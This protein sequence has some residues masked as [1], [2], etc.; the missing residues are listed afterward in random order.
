MAE[1]RRQHSSF[2]C[3]GLDD[4]GRSRIHIETRKVSPS[5]WGFSTSVDPSLYC[6][7][8]QADHRQRHQRRRGDTSAGRKCAGIKRLIRGFSRSGGFITYASAATVPKVPTSGCVVAE[9]GTTSPVDAKPPSQ[10]ILPT[11]APCRTSAMKAS[12]ERRHRLLPCLSMPNRPCLIS[13]KVAAPI[14]QPRRVQLG[15]GKFNF[16]QRRIPVDATNCR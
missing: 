5:S 16:R 10:A 6:R 3:R 1:L 14:V 7:P 2:R 11:N 8:A 9:A 4:R 13:S 12:G 15:D